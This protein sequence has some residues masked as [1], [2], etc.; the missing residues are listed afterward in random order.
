[1]HSQS[2][3]ADSAITLLWQHQR[4][5]RCSIS[6]WRQRKDLTLWK[7]AIVTLTNKR[8]SF[9]SILSCRSWVALHWHCLTIGCISELW[10]NF[11]PSSQCFLLIWWRTTIP[12]YADIPVCCHS[13]WCLVVVILR[14]CW[15]HQ[16]QPTEIL[17][18]QPHP[19]YFLHWWAWEYGNLSVQL[20]QLKKR[21]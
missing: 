15:W 4:R 16:V 6:G 18:K 19:H 17:S 13:N 21:R 20:H 10:R 2:H 9:S 3:I 7:W 12:M 8:Y 1:M 14:W 11:F 5:M